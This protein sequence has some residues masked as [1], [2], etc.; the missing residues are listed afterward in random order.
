MDANVIPKFKYAAIASVE[1]ER[2]F[3]QF[4]NMSS[5]RKMG[6]TIENMEKHLI[7]SSFRNKE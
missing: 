4:K 7:I 2:S 3:S 6:F 5:D 1:V